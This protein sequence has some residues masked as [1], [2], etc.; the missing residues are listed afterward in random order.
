M[1]FSF[2]P[3]EPSKTKILKKNFPVIF[4]KKL[5]NDRTPYKK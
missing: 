2:G 3:G 5:L 1:G 4:V